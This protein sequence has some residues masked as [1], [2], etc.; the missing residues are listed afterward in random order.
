MAKSEGRPSKNSDGQKKKPSANPDG[1]AKPGAPSAPQRGPDPAAAGSGATPSLVPPGAF[2]A[3]LTGGKSD[4][5]TTTNFRDLPPDAQGQAMEQMGLDPNAGAV[6]MQQ[7]VV[8]SLGQSPVDG[9]GVPNGLFGP[10]IP[11][12]LASLPQDM[13]ALHAQIGPMQ[14][15]IAQ[16][17]A[18]GSS[19]MEHEVAMNASALARAK[20][21]HAVGRAQSVIS[22]ADTQ[23]QLRGLLQQMVMGGQQP[24][25]PEQMAGAMQ[26]VQPGAPQL[27]QGSY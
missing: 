24:P 26:P 17:F 1:K 27:Q 16:G 15:T 23:M 7:N 13:A 11:E 6:A 22:Q 20:A 9:M 21:A 8:G 5:R 25:P 18:P 14:Q 4:A 19:N 2:A 10:G 12:E 3:S